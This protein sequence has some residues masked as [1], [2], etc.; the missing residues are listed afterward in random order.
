VITVFP[1]AMDCYRP[2][3]MQ[4]VYAWFRKRVVPFSD[5]GMEDRDYRI[6]WY[7][8]VQHWDAGAMRVVYEHFNNFWYDFHEFLAEYLFSLYNPEDDDWQEMHNFNAYAV[9]LARKMSP[10]NN[11][12]MQGQ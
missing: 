3:N 8:I 5:N 1:I 4:V 10:W 2:P 6:L 9:W 7:H 12:R 11:H